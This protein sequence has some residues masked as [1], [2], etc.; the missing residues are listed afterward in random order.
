M[1]WTPGITCTNTTPENSSNPHARHVNCESED[2]VKPIRW[3]VIVGLCLT[4]TTFKAQAQAWPAKPLKAIVP[5]AAGN[6]TDVVPRL[7]FEQL[8]TQL[9]Q[10]IIVENRP[11]GGATTGAGF[12]ATA[13]PDGYTILVNSSAHSIAPALY[14]NLG[15]DPARDF[16]G[17]I[18]LGIIPS[19]LVVPPVR[20]FRTI[21]DFVVAAKAKPG[22]LN[23]ASAGVGTATYLS[24][25]R[26][27]SSAGVQ[28][29]HVPFKGGPE[30]IAEVITGRIDFFFAPVGV[31]LPHVKEGK[32]TALVVN[33]AKRS[34]AL[35]EVPT[36]SEAGF[37]NAEY[38]FW[39]G[40]LLPAKTPRDI[41]DKLY[42]ETLKALQ[43]PTVRDKLA[44]L[45]VEPL[46]MAPGEFDAQILNEIAANAALV[47][48]SG[49]KP[50]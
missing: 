8:S 45:G 11:G 49:M 46:V 43:A 44:T 17:V 39:I 48:A 42:R 12:V 29:V 34:S 25:V 13:E 50:Q 41:V 6:V 31:A 30:A 32:L 33:S 2:P 37:S 7:V 35:P 10:S 40:I 18:P 27:Q 4:L 38:P 19:V 5:F 47:K 14:P 20:G 22:A 1:Y 23:F 26:F 28:A 36:T 9:G 24:A 21:D 16:A 3:V 15:Y